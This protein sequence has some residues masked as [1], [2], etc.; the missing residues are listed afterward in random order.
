MLTTVVKRGKMDSH[1]KGGTSLN[2]LLCNQ[3]INLK[4][5]CASPPEKNDKGRV[6]DF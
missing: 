4:C 6:F 1:K 3:L 5:D 2:W